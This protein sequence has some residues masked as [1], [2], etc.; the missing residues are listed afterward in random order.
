[1][2]RS[3]RHLYSNVTFDLKPPPN[4]SIDSA[5]DRIRH[6]TS[7]DEYRNGLAELQR[8]VVDEPPEIFL[9]CCERARAVS[10]RFDVALPEGGRDV[11]NTLRLWRPATVQQLAS[12]N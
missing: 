12:R 1:M 10:R 7:D 9:V 4:L 5:L 3:Y 6:A 8:V 11:L 2:F